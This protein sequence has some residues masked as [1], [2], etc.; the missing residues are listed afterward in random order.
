MSSSTAV[1]PQS[2]DDTHDPLWSD[3]VAAAYLAVRPAT[4]RAWR[5][6]GHPQLEFVTIGR[7]VRYRKSTL[8]RWLAQRV[9]TSTKQ[10]LVA[11]GT[12]AAPSNP[13]HA[14]QRT[15]TDQDMSS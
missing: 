10:P 12:A 15:K 6:R 11:D 14:P 2:G 5:V 3:E 4:L 1:S 9:R 13:S 7:C 8:D